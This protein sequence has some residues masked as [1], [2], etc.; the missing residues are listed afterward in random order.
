MP[1][2]VSLVESSAECTAVSKTTSVMLTGFSPCP[3]DTFMFHALV[4]GLVEG[5]NVRF[6]AVLE[7]IESLNLRAINR[8][9]QFSLT[10]LSVA[11]LGHCVDRYRVLS[12]GAA[13]G[14]GVGPLVVRRS[15]SEGMGTLS[16]LSGKRVAVPGAHTTANLLLRSF[17]PADLQLEIMPFD[18]IMGAVADGRTDAGVIIHE[19]RFTYAE[20]GLEKIADLGEVW[21]AE[22]ELPLPL[23]VICV[24]REVEAQ[25]GEALSEAL[26]AS[27]EYARANPE[28]A[29]PWIR[30]HS[31]EMSEEVCRKHID[32]YVNDYSLSLGHDGRRAIDEMFRRARA[33]G[34]FPEGPSPW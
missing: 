31:Q 5:P 18:Q 17:A 10:K 24:H 6:D 1:C 34:V 14:R 8:V 23:G 22:T 26:R 11:A 19:G 2:G 28:A 21:E 25:L 33:V 15:D 27:I 9:G 30:G 20:S 12:A 13:L 7:D 29:W 3:N 4:H 16:E 32:L